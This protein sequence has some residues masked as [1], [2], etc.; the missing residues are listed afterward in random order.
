MVKVL[1]I[2]KK[3][4]LYLIGDFSPVIL[5]SEAFASKTKLLFDK[6]CFHQHLQKSKD[7]FIS[8]RAKNRGTTF[9]QWTCHSL[10]LM[11]LYDWVAWLPSL[12]GSQHR[13]FSGLRQLKINSQLLI[14]T[15]FWVL[16]Q[17]ESSPLNQTNSLHLRLLFQ[18]YTFSYCHFSF[19]P[20]VF[21]LLK[22]ATK[23]FANIKNPITKCMESVVRYCRS[24]PS[25]RENSI[26]VCWTVKKAGQENFLKKVDI[27]IISYRF[28]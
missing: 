3:W 21:E 16:R 13:H 22:I 14:I 27:F 5:D 1:G 17:L 9:I 11:Q 18:N 8:R 24:K 19:Y 20:K 26:T 4:S 15:F 25:F 2:L 7:K 10:V 23:I 6:K 28:L 12:D